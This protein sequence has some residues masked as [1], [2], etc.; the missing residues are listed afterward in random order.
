M[1]FLRR[2]FGKERKPAEP[3]RQP[4]GKPAEPAPA[5]RAVPGMLR[6]PTP[7]G[8]PRSIYLYVVATTQLDQPAA[9]KIRNHA[10]RMLMEDPAFRSVMDRAAADR[11]PTISGLG[12]AADSGKFVEAFSF[13]LNGQNIS[14]DHARPMQG[15]KLFVQAG[16]A[17]APDGG[18][19]FRWALLGCF[20]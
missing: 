20:M 15:K 8:K 19:S 2:L 10:L 1:N 7:N 16:D 18:E 3:A 6:T 4:A 13:W 11:V 17:H 14:L 5:R 12:M 9:E